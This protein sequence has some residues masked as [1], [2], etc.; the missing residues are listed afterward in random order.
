MPNTF[1]FLTGKLTPT[2]IREEQAAARAN[3]GM[4]VTLELKEN[5]Y[6]NKNGADSLIYD[7][8]LH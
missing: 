4:Q 5:I 2:S 8:A 7:S 1:K 6:I 3:S